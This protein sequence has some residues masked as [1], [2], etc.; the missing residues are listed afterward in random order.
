MPAHPGLARAL[1]LAASAAVALTTS[2]AARSA[3]AAPP[4]PVPVNSAA[5]RR[6]ARRRRA[7]ART[8]VAPW[9]GRRPGRRSRRRPRAAAAP[10]PE[11]RSRPALR[12]P[13][14]PR[15]SPR[16]PGPA[17]TAPPGLRP[18]RRAA[19]ARRRGRRRPGERAPQGAPPHRHGPRRQPRRR[20]PRLRRLPRLRRQPAPPGRIPGHPPAVHLQL[21][22]GAVRP[23]PGT[24]QPGARHLHPRGR[25]TDADAGDFATMMYSGSGDVTAPVHPVDVTVPPAGGHPLHLRLRGRRL[26][27]LPARR[28]RPHPARHLRVRGQGGERA[29]RRR[30][31]GH[32]LQ[33]GAARPHRGAAWQPQDPGHHHPG[34]RHQLRD[35][36]GPRHRRAVPS[37]A[38][39][40]RRSP[41]PAPP[42]T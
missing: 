20:H 26:H 1:A 12:P 18:H 29:G 21:L 23:R 22:R 24:D 13:G 19:R 14:T 32:H 16:R 8:A 39:R 37:C 27:R 33:R 10:Y 35:R 6:P 17:P 41:R 31:R 38:W 42:T 11:P 40:R 28:D 4:D 34:R 30:R 15:P 25:A 5:P 9:T 7:V 2:L 3:S 36:Q